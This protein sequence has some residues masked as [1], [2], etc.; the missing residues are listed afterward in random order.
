MTCSNER[1]E[2]YRDIFKDPEMSDPKDIPFAIL[3]RLSSF[4]LPEDDMQIL[5]KVLSY[6]PDK[7]IEVLCASTMESASVAV[8]GIAYRIGLEPGAING[9][10]HDIIVA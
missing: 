6:Y 9:M 1:I 5:K 2:L 8:S 7:F 3:S 10:F 4:N